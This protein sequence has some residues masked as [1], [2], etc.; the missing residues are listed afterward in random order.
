MNLRP[1]VFIPRDTWIGA[2]NIGK[3]PISLVAVF[4]APGFEEWLRAISVTEGEKIAPLSQAEVERLR[5]LHS[6][7][8]IYQ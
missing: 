2:E 5:K 4:S 3:E 7:A 1:L 6:H 8:V